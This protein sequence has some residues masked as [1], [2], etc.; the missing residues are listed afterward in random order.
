MIDFTE[1]LTENI[2][3]QDRL[4]DSLHKN[5]PFREFKH[6]IDHSGIFRQKWFDFKNKQQQDFV[7]RQLDR[8]LPSLTVKYLK[9]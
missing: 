4:F 3:L 2:P 9:S 8:I 1:Q 7:V 5:K 6:V